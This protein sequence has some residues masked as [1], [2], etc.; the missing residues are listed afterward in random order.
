MS[1][2]NRLATVVG[3][4]AVV[5]SPQCGGA[6]SPPPAEGQDG[7]VSSIHYLA[8]Q[9]GNDVLRK[10]GNAVDAAVAVGYTLAVVHPQA[11]NIGGGGFMTI[12][13]ADGRTTFLDFREKAPLAATE[14]MYLDAAGNV[15]PKA[16]LRGYL[17]VGVP[18]TVAGLDM[19][20]TKYGTMKR[21]AVMAPAIELAEKGF[22][23][24]DFDASLLNGA[25][26]DFQKDGPSA[27]IFLKNGQSYRVGDVLVQKD[28]A[29][30][31]RMISQ[32]G[33]YA[34]Y[35]GPIA[36]AIVKS[37]QAGGGILSKADFE[38]YSAR[39]MKPIECHYKD[40]TLYSAPPPSSGG[41]TL[42]ELANI[43]EPYPLKEWG[44]NSARTVHVL[45][46]AMRH[47]YVDRNT[48]LGDPDFVSMPIERLLDKKYA[49]AIR[50]KIL[51]DKA[52]DSKDVAP[53]VAPHEGTQ[54]THYSIVD[55][56]GN[57]VAVTYTLNDF[58]GARVTAAGTGILLNDEMDDFTSKVGVANMFGLVQGKANAIAPGKRPLSS[59][60]PT[61]VTKDGK[62]A[63][64]LG[65]PGG[66]RIITITFETFL[67][68]VEFGMN[69][70]EAV[71]APRVHHQ[72]QPDQVFVEPFALSA[73][74]K[75]ILEG[76]G[77]KIVQQAPWG[78]SNAILVGSRAP[79]AAGGGSL[80]FG[81]TD[82]RRA[83]HY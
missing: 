62:V 65:S 47:A 31:L 40:Y 29:A 69:I 81:G 11:G 22:R 75:A 26:E 56:D 49:G 33:P 43:V 8:T 45:V 42:C 70:Q 14:N 28:L 76:M 54:T 21:E 71:D 37:S 78:D 39:E 12:R 57:A 16:S 15:V 67:N 1:I 38:Q 66:A 64:V 4:V 82:D 83:I 5:L 7:M 50:D 41:I 53:G 68:V 25:V 19:A 59:M 79:G 23:L 30:S 60:S 77:Y 24:G 18:G 3:T 74:T 55:K 72:W 17:A 20:L 9:I 73:D 13:F 10:G 2:F 34:F 35:R 52:S 32:M 51:P 80:Y 61:I 46:E 27:A 6:A 63:M 48:T 36:E 58:F 44:F